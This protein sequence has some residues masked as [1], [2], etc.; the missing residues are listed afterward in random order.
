MNKLVVLIFTVLVA[1]LSCDGRDRVKK[2]NAQ[3][4]SESNLFQTFKK[5]VTFFPENYTETTTDTI[6]S[7]GFRVKIKNYT[8][9]N[10]SVLGYTSVNSIKSKQYYREVISEIEVFN[11][12]KII[13]KN[14]INEDFLLENKS[15]YV[16]TE[17]YIDEL[18]SLQTNTLQLI[19]SHCIPNTKDCNTYRIAINTSGDYTIKRQS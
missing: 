10:H 2:T 18:K 13:F 9:M 7:N 16:N 12:D 19:A 8:D 11:N 14:N 3:I 4:Q 1:F 15:N 6:L 17:I 5:Q